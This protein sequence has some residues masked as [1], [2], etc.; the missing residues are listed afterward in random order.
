MSNEGLIDRVPGVGATVRK[1]NR[2][3]LN[4]PYFLRDALDITEDQREELEYFVSL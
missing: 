1:A 3:D 4:N 2:Q